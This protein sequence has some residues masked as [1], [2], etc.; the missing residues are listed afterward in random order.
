MPLYAL[1]QPP[2][3]WRGDV[4][5]LVA[6]AVNKRRLV[7]V[8][9]LPG[10]GRLVAVFRDPVDEWGAFERV[11]PEEVRRGYRME[12]PRGCGYCCAVNSGAFVLD[13]ELGSLPRWARRVVER[14]PSRVVETSRG[15]VRV[16]MLG[17]GLLGGCIFFNPETGGCRLE[18]SAGRHAKPII[19]RLTYCTLFATGPE[20]RVLRIP[21]SRT[22]K[23]RPATRR[24]W[25]EAVKAL[26]ERWMQ[27]YKA[28]ARRPPGGAGRPRPRPA[29]IPGWLPWLGS[30][31]RRGSS[32]AG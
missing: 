23:Y 3:D 28:A 19:C 27:A 31:S 8:Y 4:E 16:Y 30:T 6:A 2:G 26:R 21:G 5:L 10:S 11:D 15:A 20:G 29:G 1:R 13:V 17:T 18:E 14:Q 12:C 22:P 24:E 25:E 7:G 32:R 9:W